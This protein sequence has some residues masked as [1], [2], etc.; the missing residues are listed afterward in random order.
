MPAAVAVAEGPPVGRMPAP[1][2]VQ[3][4]HLAEVLRH[5]EVLAGALGFRAM[6]LS[7]ELIP[8]LKGEWE[9]S[10]SRRAQHLLTFSIKTRAEVRTHMEGRGCPLP[11]QQHVDVDFFF[12]CRASAP[13]RAMASLKCL[14]KQSKLPLDLGA[15]Q[16]SAKQPKLRNLPD[17]LQHAGGYDRVQVQGQ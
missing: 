15:I 9:A 16:L 1:L 11:P 5:V 4:D 14:V 10:C 7:G 6:R 8:A 13:A 17:T 3:P 2:A 12:Q